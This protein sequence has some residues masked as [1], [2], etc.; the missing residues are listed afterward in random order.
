MNSRGLLLGCA[1]GFLVKSEC[2]LA[3]V[4]TGPITNAGNGH[5]YFLLSSN[6]WTSSEVE[7][8]SL[9]G[10]LATVRNATE[11]TWIYNTFSHWT[12]TN[13]NLWIGTALQP[14]FADAYAH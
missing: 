9:G 12:G 4:L 11:Q 14:G 7:A 10:H 6:T 13:R 1:L 5:V 3:G 2:V 8:R